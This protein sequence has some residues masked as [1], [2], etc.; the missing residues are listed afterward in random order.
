MVTVLRGLRFGALLLTIAGMLLPCPA[1]SLSLAKPTGHVYVSFDENGSTLSD[2]IKVQLARHLPRIQALDIEF[3]LIIASGDSWDEDTSNFEQISLSKAR[4]NAVRQFFLDAGIAEHRIYVFG[5]SAHFS[6]PTRELYP[7]YVP[8][9][10]SA[11]IEYMGI[12]KYGY[13]AVCEAE[14]SDALPAIPPEAT[15]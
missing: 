2:S 4:A 3:I 6:P 5:Q 9:P 7:G 11:V 1:V 15:R 13:G 10:G 14:P 8:P 12:C